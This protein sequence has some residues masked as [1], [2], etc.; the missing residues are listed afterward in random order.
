MDRE[1]YY[2]AACK[3]AIH[4]ITKTGSDY[5]TIVEGDEM[6]CVPWENVLNWLDEKCKGEIKDGN[7]DR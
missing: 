2:T 5:F 4:Q 3:Y 7:G 1:R 6:L